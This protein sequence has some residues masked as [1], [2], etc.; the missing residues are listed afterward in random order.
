MKSLLFNFYICCLFVS[1]YISLYEN[2][3]LFEM[4]APGNAGFLDVF[5]RVV[6]DLHSYNQLEKMQMRR[7]FARD[8][9]YIKQLERIEHVIIG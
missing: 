7:K 1:S 4:D 9:S 6:S 2:T 5:N 8:N 3:Q